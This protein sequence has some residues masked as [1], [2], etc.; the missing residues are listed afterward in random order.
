[1]KRGGRSRSSFKEEDKKKKI[2]LSGGRKTFPRSDSRRSRKIQSRDSKT[3]DDCM[4]DGGECAVIR[5][6]LVFAVGVI[7]VLHTRTYTETF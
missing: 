7:R 5:K 1:M 3:K 4:L 6:T 2:K